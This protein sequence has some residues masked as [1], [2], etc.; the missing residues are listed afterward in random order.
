M[1]LCTAFRYLALILTSAL[2]TPT[3]AAEVQVVGEVQHPGRYTIHSDTRLWNLLQPAQ[4]KPDAYLLGAAW[5]HQPLRVEQ[6]R[7]KAGLLFQLKALEQQAWLKD[8]EQL[9]TLAERLYQQVHV[10]PVTSRRV[11]D[12]DPISIEVKVPANALVTPGDTLVYPRQPDWVRVTGAVQADCQFAYQP[13]Q[14]S[15][16]LAAR[17]ARHPAADPEYLYIVQPDGQV[18]RQGVALWNREPSPYLAPG[19]TVYVPVRFDL[20]DNAIQD[21]N[22]D[23]AQFL[24]TQPLPEEAH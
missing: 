20:L 21:L 17:C 24:A 2:S 8:N 13:G 14:Q 10:L 12:L 23:F 16:S 3:M 19:S 18:Q 15:R 9:A 1:K 22:Q 6:T 5:L 11:A 7:L 4:V